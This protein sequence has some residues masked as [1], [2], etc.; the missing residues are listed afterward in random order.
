MIATSILET[1]E[2]AT[3]RETRRTASVPVDAPV[4]AFG[5]DA[6]ADEGWQVA[7]PV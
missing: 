2:V 1:V 5:L 6:K 7:Q 4:D 3:G